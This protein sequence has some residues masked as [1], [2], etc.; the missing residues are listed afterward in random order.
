[1]EDIYY[2]IKTSQSEDV[3]IIFKT[4]QIISDNTHYI[5]QSMENVKLI[6]FIDDIVRPF[7]D[8]KI[9]SVFYDILD[10]WLHFVKN[11]KIKNKEDIKN[12][13]SSILIDIIRTDSIDLEDY[14]INILKSEFNINY[15]AE[16]MAG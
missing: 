16:T 5:Y 8:N 13:I 11:R 2:E 4:I 12:K 1:M 14:S 10:G 15:Y 7:I 6:E 9:T 3:K